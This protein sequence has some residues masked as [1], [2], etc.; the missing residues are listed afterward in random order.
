MS[1]ELHPVSEAELHAYVDDRLDEAGRVRVEAWLAVHPEERIRL[2]D[3]RDLNR[4]LH[5]LYDG[6]LEEPVPP[7]LLHRPP[8]GAADVTARRRGWRRRL[9][10]ILAL[11]A[12][13]VLGWF[14][15][16]FGRGLMTGPEPLVD[17][18]VRDAVMAHGVY[19]PAVRPFAI[20]AG[21]PQ[22]LAAWVAERMGGAIA[23]PRLDNFGYTFTGARLLPGYEGPAMQL[24]YA[25][26]AGHRL[27]LIV[28]RIGTDVPEVGVRRV[29]RHGLAALY[30]VDDGLGCAL[31]AEAN[32]GDLASAAD[33]A[34][35]Q[36]T[37]S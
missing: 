36:L 25:D 22:R 12:G 26:R 16:W 32:A 24:I 5:T 29:D 2:A 35:R 31:V 14:G 15:G 37:G 3:Y 18:L 6:V 11:C 7:A 33:S 9:L 1:E 28:V 19:G 13:L 34:Y 17:W 20:G 4:D 8:G 30:W 27:T 10:P 21:D 23:V